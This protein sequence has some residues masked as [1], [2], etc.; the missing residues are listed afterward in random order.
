[1]PNYKIQQY[2][3]LTG[4]PFYEDFLAL[5]EEA[6]EKK[7]LS[8]D[9][10]FVVIAMDISNFKFINQIYGYEIGNQLLQSLVNITVIDNYHCITACRPY[11]DQILGLYKNPKDPD[12]FDYGLKKYNDKFIS[13]NTRQF[14][15]V[16]LHLQCGVYILKDKNEKIVACVDRANMARR[17]MK[18]DYST[19][20]VIF[21]EEMYKG[22]EKT[23]EI[24]SIFEAALKNDDILVYYQPKVNIRTKKLEGAEALSRIKCQDG[25]IMAPGEYIPILE[26]SGRIIDLDFFVMRSVFH[27]IKQLLEIGS[28]PVTVSIN[29]SRIHFYN[30]RM[31]EEIIKVFKPFNIPP[32]YI[33]FEVTESAFI[34]ESGIIS[35]K[36]IELKQ[37]GFLVSMDDFGTGYSSLHSLS[38]LPIDVVKFDRSFIKNS[39]RSPKGLKIL[40]GLISLCK[41]IDFDVICEGVEDTDEEQIA[42]DCGCEHVQGYVYDKPLPEDEFLLKY[43]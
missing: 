7:Q 29:L 20:Y 23:S 35:D 37:F 18:G 5:A 42:L 1:M 43:I 24:I 40:S 3:K 41:Q 26:S 2:D 12:L 16:L 30:S 13:E 38:V 17:S 9:E 19:P 31:V 14:Q 27:M 36:L 10:Q 25:R 33:E 22:K 28:E 8:D 4:L 6:K 15:S 11:S 21:S 32:K 34:S 39:T